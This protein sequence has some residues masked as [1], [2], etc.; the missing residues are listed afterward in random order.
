ML[1]QLRLR[2][3]STE[4]CESAERILIAPASPSELS[5]RLREVRLELE[6]K[7]IPRGSAPF[8]PS[9]FEPTFNKVRV[10]LMSKVDAKCEAPMCPILLTSRFS[11]RREELRCSAAAMWLIPSGPRS[12]NPKSKLMR[13]VWVT[14]ICATDTAPWSPI[15]RK[16][17]SKS[18]ASTDKVGMFFGNRSRSLIADAAW[19]IILT[20]ESDCNKKIPRKVREKLQSIKKFK[21]L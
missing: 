20:I 4:L 7:A 18:V 19:K 13:V 8:C 3:V 6:H 12:L 17:R 10:V 5:H 15:C 21:I 1:L 2:S 16:L 11:V 9:L 14:K